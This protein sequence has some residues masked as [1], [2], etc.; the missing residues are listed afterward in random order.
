KLSRPPP[1]VIIRLRR[2]LSL[3]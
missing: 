3:E 2:S 1:L